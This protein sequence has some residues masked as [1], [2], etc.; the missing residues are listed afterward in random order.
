MRS[1]LTILFVAV[2]FPAGG[3]IAWAQESEPGGSFLQQQR[4]IDEKLRE[5]RLEL[6]PFSEMFDFQWGGWIEYYL[7][8]FDDG[9]QKS[10]LVQRPGMSLWTRITIDGGAHILFARAKLRYTHFKHGDEIDWHDD[11]WGPNFDRAWYQIDVGKA[12]RLN[13]PS[14]PYQL[15]VRIGRQPVLLGTG[16]TLDMPLDAVVLDG[17]LRDFRVMGLFGKTIGSYP[18]IDRSEPV[19]SHSHRFFYGVQLAYEGWEKHV[20]FVYALWND[21]KTDERPIEWSQN[22]SYDT[23]YFGLG[24]RGELAYNLFYWVEG[25]F[26]SGHSF[27]DGDFLH[28]DRVE[29]YALDVGLEYLFNTPTRPRISGEYMFASGDP[30]R[31]LS[32]TSAQGGNYGDRKDTGF[33]AFGYRDTGIASGLTPS[34]LHIWR[35]GAS[36]A[37]LAKH[38]V[39]K[40]FEIGTNCFLYHKNNSQAAISDFTADEF[41]GY[42][43]WE[44]DYFV[45]WRL[46]SDISWTARWGVFFPGGAF[47]DRD[48]RHFIF[49]GLTWSF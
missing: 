29:A 42:V 33:A 23:F 9:V 27:G 34:N 1:A 15:K 31:I 10:R 30:D 43:G 35:I 28:R 16:Y 46:A 5:E 8:H 36:C 12:F 47:S 20:P 38:Q 37:P 19:D 4:L 6:A 48:T 22:Y 26:E 2:T 7:F 39:F 18:N 11:W 24:S 45:N 41:D 40:D 13:E 21:D 49:T 44:M 32:P 3:S 17:R 14:D 25:V